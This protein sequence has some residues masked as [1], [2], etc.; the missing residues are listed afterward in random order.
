MARHLP[1]CVASPRPDQVERLPE[2]RLVM[3][4]RRARRRSALTPRLAAPRRSTRWCHWQ[5]QGLLLADSDRYASPKPGR[6]EP[7]EET[8]EI[9]NP[10]LG[11]VVAVALLISASAAAA[12]D[13]SRTPAN[14]V[15]ANCISDGLYGNEPNAADGTDGGPAEHDPGE[16]PATSCRRSRLARGSTDPADPDNPT[17][18]QVNWPAK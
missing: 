7:E 4:Q 13:R 11:V 2:P 5:T 3:R 8:N 10:T 9:R 15:P 6:L 14:A 16:T 18:G 17:R 1:M 12:A